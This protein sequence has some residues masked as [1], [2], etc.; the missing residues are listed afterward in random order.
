[1]NSVND[2]EVGDILRFGFRNIDVVRG[3]NYQPVSLVGRISKA[4]RKRLRITIPDVIDR[5]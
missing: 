1:V 2:H 4:E 5:L 3:V